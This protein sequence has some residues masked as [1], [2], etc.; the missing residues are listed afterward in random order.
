MLTNLNSFKADSVL[1][2]NFNGNR[3]KPFLWKIQGNASSYLFGT[4]HVPF[5][6]VWNP[7]KDEIMKT[8]NTSEKLYLEI[9]M[10]LEQN[11]QDFSKCVLIHL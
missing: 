4:M 6:E 11:K 1:K 10:D 9:D 3:N 5:V 8:F 7:I 2:S